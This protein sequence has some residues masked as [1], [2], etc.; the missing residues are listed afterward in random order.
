ME[1]LLP[2]R[3]AG[4]GR[5]HAGL[6]E[7]VMLVLD[8]AYAEYL[9][10]GFTDEAAQMVEQYDNVV[11]TRTFSK[12]HG[13]AAFRLGWAYCPEHILTTIGSIRGPFSVNSAAQQ[14]GIIAI[15]DIDF[16]ALSVAHNDRWIAEMT[17]FL[18]QLGLEVVPS[19][20]NFLLIGFDNMA[21][22]TADEAAKRLAQD[23]ILKLGRSSDVGSEFRIQ[24]NQGKFP[25]LQ[26]DDTASSMPTITIGAR[27]DAG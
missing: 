11:M 1:W 8:W 21:H 27:P 17:D 19:M 2:T 14:A 6:P 16:Q 7:S 5:L 4:C 10:D 13:L 26:A 15:E 24:F 12:L 3:C 20:T 9:D 22:L 25:E 23:G 18:R